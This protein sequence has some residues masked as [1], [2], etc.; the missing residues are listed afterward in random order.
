VVVS[1]LAGSG[2]SDTHEHLVLGYFAPRPEVAKVTLFV[3]V[4]RS[5]EMARRSLAG[6]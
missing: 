4:C 2:C 5:D 3:A 1:L 6:L